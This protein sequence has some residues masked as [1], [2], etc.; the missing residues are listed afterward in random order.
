M[1]INKAVITA[2]GRRQ[3]TL[4]LQTLIDR[5]GVEKSVLTILIEEVLAAG[6]DEIGVVVRP[7]DEQAYAQVAGPHAR[8]LHF[9]PQSEPLGHGHAVYCAREF[10]GRD[11]F[12]HLVG[13]HLYVSTS[14]QR[15]AQALVA[16]A[17]TEACAISAVQATRE[18]LLPYYGAVGGRRVPGA[19]A[20]YEVDTVIEKPTP[21]QAEQHLIVPGLRAG[22]YLCFFGMHVLTP[23]VM[24]ILGA[25]IATGAAGEHP[26][27]G[28]TLSAALVELAHREKYL[29]LEQAGARYDVG[30]KYGLLT[31]QMALALT[32]D[33]REEVLARLL[34]LLVQREATR[35]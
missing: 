21:T 31:A 7:G 28:Y 10:V 35:R 26:E 2:A 1:K 17:E 14:A 4:P 3:R 11:P 29:A 9:V 13:D 33:D 6:I 15:C 8:R 18:S 12:L 20:L 16:V 32:G 30:V 22:Y 27:R 19:P 5:D 24:S 34:E 23:S 25:Q